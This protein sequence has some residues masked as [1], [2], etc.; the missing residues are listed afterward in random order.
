MIYAGIEYEHREIELKDKPKS[1][2]EYSPK[3]TVPVLV[4]SQHRVIDQSLDIMHWA[5][6]QNDPDHWLPSEGSMDRNVMDEWIAI[7]DGRFKVLL[8]TYK[9]PQRYLQSN[10]SAVFE[11][12]YEIYLSPLNSRLTTQT[13][14]L[15]DQLSM[16]DIALFP[17]VR[18][19]VAVDSKI[20]HERGL[21]HLSEWLNFFVLSDLFHTAMAK[22]PIWRDQHD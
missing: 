10:Q 1:M 14:L 5:L 20:I 2:L 22:Y 18:Q 16:L 17:F 7:N 21:N 13:F 8:D 3:G 11:E 4:T 19:F 15:G 6:A 9:Y 12:A